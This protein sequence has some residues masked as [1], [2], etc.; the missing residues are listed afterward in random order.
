MYFTQSE[1]STL[2]DNIYHILKK[3]GGCW[4]TA[5]PEAG[6]Q[7]IMTA[8]PLYKEK[9]MEIM[10]KAKKRTEKISDVDIGV[11]SLIIKARYI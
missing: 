5:D 9:F 11:N 6:L 1:I 4:I 2:C 10:A 7:Y 3:R 8:Q